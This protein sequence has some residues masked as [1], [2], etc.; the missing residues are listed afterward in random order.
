MRAR[1]EGGLRW[2]GRGGRIVPSGTG[3]ASPMFGRRGCGGRIRELLCGT[4]TGRVGRSI[5]GSFWRC[6]G[7]GV[8]LLLWSTGGGLRGPGGRG[9]VEDVGGGEI[10]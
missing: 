6:R 9:S 7:R 3:R 10:A 8:P 1:R 4:A 5:V 2:G